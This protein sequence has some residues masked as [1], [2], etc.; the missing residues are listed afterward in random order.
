[1]EQQVNRIFDPSY[2]VFEIRSQP[3][4]GIFSPK[5]VAVIGASERP[6]SVGRTLLWNLI[7]NPFGGTV[8]PVNPKRSSVLGI[9]AYPSI[10]QVPEEVD[11]AVIATPASTVPAIIS[12]CADA[13]VKGAII[14]SAGFKEVGDKGR[15][16]EAEIQ[17]VLD[18]SSMRVIGPNCLG[19]MRPQTGL[20]ATFAGAMARPGNVAFI[21]QSGALLTSILDW[22]FQANV[23][24]STFVSTGSM[25]DVGWGDLI[26]YLG[27]DPKTE[28]ILIYM[29]SIGD[30]RSFISAAREV[31]LQ[32][33]IIVIKS[34]RTREA[35]QAAASHTGA[36]TG[37]DE[38]LDAAFRRAGVLRADN[39][40]DL[41]YL[42]EVL[43]KQP[44]P[45]G[46]R[47][48]VITNAGG[49]GVLATDALVSGGGE[50]TDLS[51]KAVEQYNEFLPS[52]WS[53]G[54]PVDILGD[55]GADR[56]KNAV[57]V[58]A[59]DENSDGLLVI[60]TP[61]N[62]TEPTQIAEQL[63]AY[64]E[65]R[66]GRDGRS[67]GGTSRKP[68]LASWMGG[69]TVS[70][71][72]SIL[73]QSGI[74]TF[75]YP[76]TAA[77]VFNYM[78][79]YNYNL[80][81]L[82]ET[83]RLVEAPGHTEEQAQAQELIEKVRASGRTL[84]TEHESKRLL[85]I[86]GIPTVETRLA[87]NAFQAVEQAEKMGY[88]VVCKLHSE[89]VTHKTDVGGVK[90]NLENEQQVRQAFNEIRSR[91]EEMGR[92]EA[93]AGVSIQ[94][95]VNLDGYELI[96]GS[97]H[98]EQ[99]GPV[100]L[101]GSG[102]SLVEVYRDRALGLPP[103][104]ST[105]ARRMMEQTKVYEAL[106]GV[107]GRKSVDMD[108]LNDLMV[109]FSQLVAE[110]Q[111]VKEID[112]NPLLA[113]SK[114]LLALDAR[115]VLHEADIAQEQLPSLAIRPYPHQY[116]GKWTM[117]DGTPVTIRPIAPEDEPL[118]VKFHEELSEQSVYLRYASLMKLS[119]RVAHERL[120]RICHVDYDREMALV[121]EATHPE[122]GEREI[123]GI[124][125]L[126]KLH[127]TNDGEFALLISDRYQ[128][129]RLGTELLRRLVEIGRQ[130]GLDHILADILS[131]NM[132][133]QR[134]AEKLG[135]Y[136]IGPAIEEP[137]MKAVKL[138]DGTS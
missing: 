106:K 18:R 89:S 64:A 49:P 113:S 76:D 70:A 107:R 128:Q 132:A 73:N 126:T 60:L 75:T 45:K 6:G 78:W 55:A 14:I 8:F 114:Q 87:E 53:H 63:S 112:I 25:L 32:K 81:A 125:R 123:A 86:Y 79:R 47:L 40:A 111:L 16:L 30:A 77:R 33:P 96:V 28:S 102:G 93:F 22:S 54:N 109:R 65:G 129:K 1:M 134:V 69:N 82:Y 24:F 116:V 37:S 11:L 110:Q 117:G 29:E 66:S 98:D 68:I 26:Y 7:S 99:F 133:M 57:E 23:G 103:L 118:L 50:L 74:P 62:M 56:Y 5:S 90:L 42:A 84:L 27:D 71:G 67:T 135:F 130:E 4:D 83:P 108:A 34:G 35:A 138:L 31:A 3:L 80:R 100:L 88:P 127:G 61:Q 136:L 105:L 104:N 94:P 17:Q 19:V 39:I 48:T 122:T 12:E 15:Q 13:E 52:A 137:V 9:K 36:L 2:D 41:F 120:V 58:A 20:N 119:K 10:G 121:A 59:E 115:V 44:R 85:S 91:L 43:A 21:S 51:E 46:N 97:S 124:G 72:E 131:Q 101:F 38:V 92:P 95:M